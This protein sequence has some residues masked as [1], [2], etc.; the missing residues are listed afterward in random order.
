M[1]GIQWQAPFRRFCIRQGDGLYL[2]NVSLFLFYLS[3][4]SEFVC[5]NYDV[6]GA[7]A[8]PGPNAPMGAYHISQLIKFGHI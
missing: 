5:R 4:I 6:W 8:T 1:A 3:N 2:H 7:S